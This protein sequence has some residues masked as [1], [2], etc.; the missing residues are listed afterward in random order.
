MSANRGK[1]KKKAPPADKTTET[2]TQANAGKGDGADWRKKALKEYHGAS[3]RHVLTIE[4]DLTPK[5]TNAAFGLAERLRLC[6]NKVTRILQKDIDQLNRN[7]EYRALR[8]ALR[9]AKTSIDANPKDKRA[10]REKR[11]I[12][13]RLKEL[14]KT[15]HV[16]EDATCKL[17]SHLG[18]QY[19]IP[20]VFADTRAKDI[21]KGAEKILYS[22]GKRLG[23]RKRDDLPTLRAKERN[24]A[25][26]IK[27]VNGRLMFLCNGIHE[28]VPFGHKP[29]DRWQQDEVTRILRYLENPDGWDDEAIRAMLEDGEVIETFRPCYATLVCEEIRD[30][31]RVLIHITVEGTPCAKFKSDGVTPRHEWGT[32][33]VGVDIGTQTIAWTSDTEVGLKNLSERGASIEKIE[34]RE[35]VIQRKMDRSRRA[36]NP[37]NYNDD[38]TVRRGRK[39]WVRSNRYLVL[40]AEHRELCRRAALNRQY[41]IREDANRLRELG[42]EAITEPPNF[43]ALQRRAR[44][45]GEGAAET[46][47]AVVSAAAAGAGVATSVVASGVG[48]AGGGRPSR[49][50]RFGRSLLRRCPGAFQAALRA[51]FEGTGGSYHEVDRNFRASQYDHVA[52]DYVKKKLGCRA[53]RLGPPGG[54]DDGAAGA[55]EGPLVQRDLYSSFLL[56][57]ANSSFASP[58]RDGCLRGFEEFKRRQDRCMRGIARSGRR[59]F[60]SGSRRWK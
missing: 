21:W 18:K 12:E 44:P 34:R 37:G 38:G 59:V 53:F 2:A 47:D 43:K 32:G 39:E 52:D 56:Y 3:P 28:G 14:R 36:T 40:Q 50:K 17:M 6:G 41:A 26:L 16:T 23:Y 19:D 7:K 9:S 49:R 24:S 57:N 4:A 5:E 1:R 10:K 51:R 27:N 8:R 20:S 35:R 48:G 60:N 22:D 55:R 29:L 45:K 31:R 11:R 42:D 13:A 15:H 46:A 54:G 25:T 58:S 33:R 30:K